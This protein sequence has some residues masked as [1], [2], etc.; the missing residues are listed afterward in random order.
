MNCSQQEHLPRYWIE[1]TKK[2]LSEECA[3]AQTHL[4]AAE[5]EAFKEVLDKKYPDVFDGKLGCYPHAK[6]N[7]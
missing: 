4:S 7:V 2:G 6:I 1:P 3:S 5:Q